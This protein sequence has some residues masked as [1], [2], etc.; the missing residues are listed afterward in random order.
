MERTNK[1]RETER[2]RDRETKRQGD[3]ETERQRDRETCAN[4]V[5]KKNYHCKRES[6]TLNSVKGTYNYYGVFVNNRK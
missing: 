6:S 1:D 4:V 5:V 2:Q 3:R